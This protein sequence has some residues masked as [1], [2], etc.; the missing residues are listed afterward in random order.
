MKAYA[1]AH[2]EV[3]QQGDIMRG[4]DLDESVRSVESKPELV[5]MMKSEGVSPREFVL[6]MMTIMT[7]GMWAAMS[8]RY[9]D[10]KM[11]PRSIRGT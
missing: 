9:P 2:P 5:S 11:P 3:R 4:K 8:Q 10:A 7:A 1:Q 6:G